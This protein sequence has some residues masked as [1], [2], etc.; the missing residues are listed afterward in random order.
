[1]PKTKSPK[2]PSA[3]A[4][5]IKS[6]Y[7]A[8]QK[9]FEEM[10]IAQVMNVKEVAKK[11]FVKILKIGGAEVLQAIIRKDIL[12]AIQQINVILK[13]KEALQII[14]ELIKEYTNIYEYNTKYIDEL[15]QC[16]N[17]NC[18]ENGKLFIKE[19]INVCIN[20][21]NVLQDKQIKNEFTKIQSITL[22]HAK[23]AYAKI[24]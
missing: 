22:K 23:K 14:R 20:I 15:I 4:L 1:M 19:C 3:N 17:I 12:T 5:A 11:H 16:F 21:S 24:L 8:C 2:S 18:D 7:G 9:T 13:K 6:C 10:Q